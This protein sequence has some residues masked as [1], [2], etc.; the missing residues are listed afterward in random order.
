[1]AT[2]KIVRRCSSKARNGG[3][4]WFWPLLRTVCALSLLGIGEASAFTPQFPLKAGWLGADTAASI[5]LDGRHR[6]LWLFS[7]TYVRQDMGTNRHGAGM[8]NNSLAITTWNGHTT[9]IDYYIRGRDQ[10]AMTSI[11]PSPGSD[12]NGSWWY[13]V[14][15][16]FKYNGKIYVFLDRNRHTTDPG[17][18]LSGFQ[19]FATDMAVFDNVD[20]EPNPLNWPLTLKLDVLDSTI[21]TPGVSTYVDTNAGYAYLWGNKDTVVSGWHYRSFLLFRIALAAL[22]NPG[23]NLQYYTTGGVWANATGSDLSDAQIIMTSGSPDFSIRYHPDLGKCV[24]VQCDDGFPSSKIWARMS[25]SQLSGWPGKTGATTLVNL[26]TEPG[27]MAWPVFYYA[28]KEHLEFYSPVTGQ[29]LLTYCG[30]STDISSATLTNVLNNNS[31]YVPVPRWV[32]LGT[33]HV[34]HAPNLCEITSPADGQP[35][36]G[37]AD[38][39]VSVNATDADAYDGIVLVNVFLDGVLAAST[40]TAPFDCTLRGVSAG[41]HTLYAEAYDTAESKTTSANINISVTPY[42]VTQYE[43][44][45]REYAPV[46]YWRFNETNGSALAYEDYNR[47][48]ATYGAGTTNGVA[49]VPSPPFRGFETNNAGVALKTTAPSGGTGYVTAPALNLNTNTVSIVAWLYPFGPVTNSAGV[50]F[51][52]G[53]TYAVGLGYMG[54]TRIP[55]NEIGYTWNQNNANTYNWPSRLLVP[56]GQWSFVALT[57]APTQATFYLG[58][59]GILNSSTNAI[60]HD[61]ELWDGPTAIGSDTLSGP[62]RVFNGEI[63]EVAIF[64]YTL[65]PAQVEALYSLALAGPP[66]TLSCQRSGGDIMLS[67]PHGTLLQA[68][69]PSGTWTPVAGAAPPSFS[70]TPLEQMYYRVQVYP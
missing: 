64:N 66:M 69:D 51:S 28:A 38:V 5:P 40:G 25:S 39:A 62:S 52:R 2:V 36:A 35:F 11:F 63:D 60:A 53:S 34:N 3:D 37:P 12:A 20:T 70:V 21:Y 29:A 59:N 33:A 57:V 13:W 54:G 7:D 67:W 1:M 46:Y 65:S 22:E 27:Y 23:A 9:N 50:V 10:G 19:Q 4:G 18:A 31:L 16:G 49:G 47:L 15:D 41:N 17:G 6:I 8:V 45:V 43:A 14:Q 68:T 55:P 32:Q 26:P 24:D 48:N 42:G 30:N 56:P 44:Q 61:V 58:T